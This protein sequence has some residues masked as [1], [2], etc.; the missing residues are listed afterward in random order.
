MTRRPPTVSRAGVQRLGKIRAHGAAVSPP[1]E[2]DR[3][4]NTDAGCLTYLD[5][6]VNVER[7]RLKSA[8]P[9][10][11]KL[12]RMRALLDVLGSP[13][14][15]IR[16]VHVAGSKGKGSTC[17]MISAALEGCGLTVGLYTS[18]HLVDVR[19]RVQINHRPISPAA[20]TEAIARVAAASDQVAQAFGN[21]TYFEH[22]TAAAFLYFAEQAV[23]LAVIEVGLGGRLDSTNV[24]VPEVC[25]VT[26]IQLEHTHLLGDSL[27]AIA[28]EKAGIFKPDVPAVTCQQ[29]SPSVLAAIR[30]VA[31]DVGA[32]LEVLG[33]TIDF[34][35]RFEAN[36]ELGPHARVV[37]TT[38]GSNFE[39]IAVPLRGEHQSI[40]C[41]LALAVV[42]KLRG[43][44]F[45]LPD[46]EVVQGL[47]RTRNPG[48]M[49]Q[50]WSSPRV[51]ID[52]AHNPE[53]VGGVMKALGAHLRYDS[54]V[55]IF[56]C[57][58]DKNIL[59]MLSRIASGADKVIFT[60]AENNARAADPRDLQRRFAEVSHKMSLTAPTLKDAI[61]LAAR[62]VGR[63]DLICIT[64]S[65]YI[66]GEARRLFEAR[67]RMGS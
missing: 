66:A 31:S 35:C 57:A 6:L 54:L 46:R 39:H 41:G 16:C 61:N 50:V 65:F 62:A 60:R 14:Q 58:A 5:G 4:L 42:D 26:A 20:F 18:P 7:A 59:G 53:S 2:A 44:G 29:A 15:Q 13:H 30:E 38:A 11:F 63:D 51:I 34:S 47:A 52:G 17:H 8:D 49:E 27:E 56:G 33:E 9:E 67:A 28:R 19:E 24:V 48:R 21:A 12:D 25:V 1:V 64:G 45:R 23:D 3:D 36:Q 22:L 10:I 43:R 55:V 40:N 37:L 32:T